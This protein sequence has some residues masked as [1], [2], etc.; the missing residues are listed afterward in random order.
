MHVI[1]ACICKYACFFDT[2]YHYEVMKKV[3]TQNLASHKG[4]S[5]YSSAYNCLLDCYGVDG[6]RKILRLYWAG[7]VIFTT[8]TSPT[9]ITAVKI[10]CHVVFGSIFIFLGSIMTGIVISGTYFCNNVIIKN[11][12]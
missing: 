10:L 7:A 11:T 3:E 1:N 4:K 8:A 6:I 9:G 5:I 12:R 2:L